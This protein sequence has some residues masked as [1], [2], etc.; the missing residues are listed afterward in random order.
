[1]ISRI[2]KHIQENKIAILLSVLVISGA[3]YYLFYY[4]S[5]EECFS[6]KV[7]QWN[8]IHKPD[9]LPSWQEQDKFPLQLLSDDQ[10]IVTAYGK[11]I[12]REFNLED[13]DTTYQKKLYMALGTYVEYCKVK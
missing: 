12:L 9:P 2:I 5:P 7:E 3:T 6:N 13:M 4:E 8:R 11:T 1:M 10:K